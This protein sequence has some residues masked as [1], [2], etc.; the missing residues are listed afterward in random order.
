MAQIFPKWAN[1][2]PK[3]LLLTVN[4]LLLAVIFGFWYWGS[5]E[6][7]QVG[8]APKQP[9]DYSHRLHAGELGIDCQYCHGGVKESA[10]A[11]IPTTE[12]CMA[13]HSQIATNSEKLQPLRDAWE[14]EKPVEWVHIHKL[15]GFAYFNH[16]SHVNVG[17]GCATCHGRVDRMEVVMQAENLSMGWCLDCHNNPEPHLRPVDQV[18]NMEWQPG[19]NH[20]EFAQA[21]IEKKNINPPIYCNSCHR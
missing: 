10:R 13:C 20:F 16:S 4:L 12:T 15:P 18:T 9:I 17:V 11:G 8:Y 5:P 14:S 3:K 19:E 2:V 1:N 7:T 21:V 6:F